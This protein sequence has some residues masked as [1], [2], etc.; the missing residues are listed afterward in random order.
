MVK[1]MAKLYW[2]S[3]QMVQAPLYVQLIETSPDNFLQRRPI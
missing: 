2:F 1:G 3:S